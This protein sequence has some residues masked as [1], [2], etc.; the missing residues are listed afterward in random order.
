MPRWNH[1]LVIGKFLPP[2]LGHKFLIDTA[3]SQ[4]DRL[5]V[6]ICDRPEY[7]VDGRLR[8]DWLEEIHPDCEIL[9]IHD[10]LPDDDSYLWAE[11]TK[12]V[13]GKSPDVVFTSEDYGGPY[14][15]FLGCDHV[16][17]DK[18]REAVPCSG[19]LI[20]S[21]PHE[22]LNFL[23]PCVRAHFVKRICVLGAESSGTTTL[24][25]ALAERYQTDWVP[26][27]GR[28]YWIEKM[29]KGEEEHW[30]ED[31]FVHIATEQSRREDIAARTANRV[32]F[33]DTD[34]FATSL[35]FQRYMDRRSETVEAVPKDRPY[36]LYFLT[37][38]NIPFEQ[39]G[40]RDGE[41]IR[42]WMHDLFIDRLT[43]THRPYH[44]LTG[45]H[46]ARLNEALSTLTSIGIPPP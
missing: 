6:M 30:T 3:R 22:H 8:A 43:E 46:E 45:P 36:A 12:R 33:C 40:Y 1:G 11:N 19:T 2:H 5:T 42:H 20:R 4:V 37:D 25:Q 10:D 17:V 26:E 32:L 18:A 7:G 23:A 39:D 15:R 41:H 29:R 27:Y 34:A 16:L 35:W 38:V 28:E 21:N 14:S 31:E 13:L 9:L 44:L 24:A